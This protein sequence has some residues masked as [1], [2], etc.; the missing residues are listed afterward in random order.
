MASAIVAAP[1]PQTGPKF[2]IF[3]VSPADGTIAARVAHREIGVS[4]RQLKTR[5]YHLSGHRKIFKA[6][7]RMC[8]YEIK[9]AATQRARGLCNCGSESISLFACLARLSNHGPTVSRTRTWSRSLRLNE[10]KLVCWCLWCDGFLLDRCDLV[11]DKA[12]SH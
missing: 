7:C 4:H 2:T 11:T 3:R 5:L 1:A 9:T 12:L 10:R 6:R 8:C